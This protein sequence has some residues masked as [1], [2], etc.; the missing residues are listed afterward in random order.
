M[1]LIP[2]A[3]C[4][5]KYSTYPW[6]FFLSCSMKALTTGRASLEW[7][8][9]LPAMLQPRSIWSDRCAWRFRWLIWKVWPQL[10]SVPVLWVLFST[11]CRGIFIP[12]FLGFAYRGESLWKGW[13]SESLSLRIWVWFLFGVIFLW[14]SLLRCSPMSCLSERSSF[15]YLE[16]RNLRTRRQNT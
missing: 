4:I 3:M 10:I 8:S 16:K 12:I 6:C 2:E 9:R 15:M 13:S 1:R 7:R 5:Y 14:Y 11:N